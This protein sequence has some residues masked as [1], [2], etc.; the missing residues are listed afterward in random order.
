[1]GIEELSV[2]VRDLLAG[3][4]DARLPTLVERW[5]K[6]E[7]FS[8]FGSVDMEYLRSVAEDLVGLA[9]RAKERDQLLYCWMCA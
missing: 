2:N 4:D 8:R 3:A 1:M 7:E 5:A 6:T 9:R